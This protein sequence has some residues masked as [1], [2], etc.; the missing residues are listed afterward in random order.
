VNRAFGED[1][2]Q[3]VVARLLER[4]SRDDLPSM[5]NWWG[6]GFIVARHLHWEQKEEDRLRSSLD[7]DFNPHMS[8]YTTDD[9]LVCQLIARDDLRRLAKCKHS[10]RVLRYAL[11]RDRAVSR[12]YIGQLRKKLREEL[13]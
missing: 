4:Y 7:S 1:I 8:E 13:E 3:E 12:Q 9:S 6:Y 10:E 11:Y 5:D 2:A